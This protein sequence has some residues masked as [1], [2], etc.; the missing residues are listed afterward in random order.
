[1]MPVKTYIKLGMK[2][3]GGGD[4]D[5]RPYRDPLWV[6]EKFVTR[7]DEKGRVWNPTEKVTRQEGLWMMTNWAA[8]NRGDEKKMGTIEAGKLADL[9]VLD[10]DYMAVPEDDISKIPVV[11][12]VVG[13]KVVY[14]KP[15]T[16]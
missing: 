2:P 10:A 15:G 6:I 8:Y 3:S 14:E 5:G 13:G 9:V 4:I 12:T 1:M 11:M 7:K 16:F